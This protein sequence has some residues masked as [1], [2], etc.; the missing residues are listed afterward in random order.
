MKVCSVLSMILPC[1]FLRG[2]NKDLNHFPI[3]SKGHLFIYSTY[4]YWQR[5]FLE[6]TFT[7]T[8]SVDTGLYSESKKAQLF[9]GSTKTQIQ[10][11][12]T[13]FQY[14]SLFYSLR[15]ST[16]K[17]TFMAW[18]RGLTIM[19]KIENVSIVVVNQQMNNSA[20]QTGDYLFT[21]Q[22]FPIVNHDTVSFSSKG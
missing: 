22:L 15:T 9:I 5:Q 20:V 12:K 2:C 16:V 4:I 10:K 21:R 8:G 13:I 11:R 17:L 19:Y 1:N 14:S 18:P 7:V 3:I 6:T